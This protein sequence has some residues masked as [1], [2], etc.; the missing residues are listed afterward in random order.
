MLRKFFLDVVLSTI[1]LMSI[2]SFREVK[3][4]MDLGSPFA[5]LEETLQK[6][7]DDTGI[8][9]LSYVLIKNGEIVEVNALGYANV[10]MSV[11]A[12]TLTLYNQGSN[13]KS[14]TATAIMQLQDKGLL[15]IDAPISDYIEVPFNALASDDPITARH[16]MSHQ[17]GIP[18]YVLLNKIWEFEED[19]SFDELLE[20]V[21]P[22][23]APGRLYQYANNGYVLLAKL[24]EEI[25]GQSYETYVWESI[26][27]PLGI[28][29]RGFVSPTPEMVENMALPYHMR[30]NR[31]YPTAQVKLP[32][33]PSGGEYLTPSDM[34]KFLMMQLNLGDFKG[35]K[36]LTPESV[37]E[38]HRIQ[39]MVEHRFGYGLGFAVVESDGKEYSTH[40]GS[41][42]GF[43]AAFRMDF[44]SRSAVYLSTNVTASPMQERQLQKLLDHMM[45]QL[46]GSNQGELEYPLEEVLAEAKPKIDMDSYVGKYRIEGTS[47][48]LSIEK[49]G[50]KIFLVNPA[51]ER[52]RLEHLKDHEFFLTTEDENIKFREANGHIASMCLLS[53]D[54]IIK[55]NKEE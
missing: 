20:A 30:Y 7:L 54:S 53:A 31:A 39:I 12:D 45:G 1:M 41:L 50:K 35:Q 4:E 5:H 33:F 15:D 36:I 44:D 49:I 10:R 27:E 11:P 52:F 17:S 38:M 42:P 55:A 47:A 21:Q 46:L 13:F 14:V 9:S 29:N 24:I 34:A 16:L 43:L 32:Q 6:F 2:F 23:V 18:P 19:P 37:R 26:L 22:N 51:N 25:T 3:K 28:E 8:P 40:Q 48:F